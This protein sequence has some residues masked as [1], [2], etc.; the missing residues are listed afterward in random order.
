MQSI[1]ARSEVPRSL[2]GSTIQ[3]DQQ[4]RPQHASKAVADAF[5]GLVL[6][7]TRCALLPRLFS[8][9]PRRRNRMARGVSFSGHLRL[10]H[11]SLK[12]QAEQEVDASSDEPPPVN[13]H[14]SSPAE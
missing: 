1:T 6:G 8:S 9:S 7:E 13:I 3:P 2:E 4:C 14:R 10:L 5:L 11:Q 12:E